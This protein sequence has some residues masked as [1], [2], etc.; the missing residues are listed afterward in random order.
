[1]KVFWSLLFTIV[2]ALTL[3]VN[4]Q[5]SFSQT[6][7]SGG[8]TSSSGGTTSYSEG[9]PWARNY[10]NNEIAAF[11]AY[12]IGAMELKLAYDITMQNFQTL[13]NNVKSGIPKSVILASSMGFSKLDLTQ[14]YT[15][16]LNT[17]MNQVQASL[18]LRQDI[19]AIK[20]P[21][22]QLLVM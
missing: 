13:Y 22:D 7:S 4:V 20:A 15:A 10:A 12:I 17:G 2:A 1:M 16:Y 8:T 21:G 5:P 18:Q 3:I 14:R 9:L 19:R 11:R 6:S